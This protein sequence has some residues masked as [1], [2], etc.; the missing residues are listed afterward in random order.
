MKE[1]VVWLVSE[2]F[3]R[4]VMLKEMYLGM[5]VVKLKPCCKVITLVVLFPVHVKFF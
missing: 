3:C 2:G 1:S 5:V 4:P